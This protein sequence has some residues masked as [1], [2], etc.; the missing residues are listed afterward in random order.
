MLYSEIFQELLCDFL[1]YF[2]LS[3]CLIY[4]YFR[5]Q[6][7]IQKKLL[8]NLHRKQINFVLTVHRWSWNNLTVS[9]RER[10]TPKSC[11]TNC[12]ASGLW[13]LKEMSLS[14]SSTINFSLHGCLY[15]MSTLAL[16][17]LI[18]KQLNVLE[19]AIKPYCSRSK[20]INTT[21]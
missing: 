9:A 20:N 19:F 8:N 13:R 10:K 16:W 12:A 4:L 2:F 1:M 17:F 18:T 5:Q 14:G 3:N 15:K 11:I 7:Y 21:M 6:F